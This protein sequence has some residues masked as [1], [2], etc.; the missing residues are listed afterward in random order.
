[1]PETGYDVLRTL[2]ERVKDDIVSQQWSIGPED[3]K[4][5]RDARSD[6]I[7]EFL[8]YPDKVHSWDDWLR[9]LL[10]QMLVYDAPAIWLRPT[11]GGDPYSLELLDGAMIS[12]KIMA[13]GRLP[14]P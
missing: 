4:V 5:K 12:P 9:M 14:P 11:R 10:E 6:E 2:I 8:E 3:K 1:A 7:E 13:D